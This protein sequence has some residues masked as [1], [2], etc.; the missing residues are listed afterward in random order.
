VSS[1]S[2]KRATK[3]KPEITPSKNK[4][5]RVGGRPRS[6][7]AVMLANELA[8]VPKGATRKRLAEEG[9]IKKIQ[10]RREMSCDEVLSV[11]E[12]AFGH[13]LFKFMIAKKDNSMQMI[14]DL[15]SG[16]DVISLTSSG[17]SLYMCEVM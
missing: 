11:I 16:E 6:V 7:V 3:F 2:S 4:K 8:T 14:D 17:A 9:R 10:F 13:K 1:S 12:R 5:Q 15:I